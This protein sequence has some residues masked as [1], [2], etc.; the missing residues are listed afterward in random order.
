MEVLVEIV[1]QKL[2]GLNVL[3]RVMGLRRNRKE[4]KGAKNAKLS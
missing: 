4:R 1:K 3:K 2:N